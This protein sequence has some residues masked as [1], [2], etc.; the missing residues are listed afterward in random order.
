M[1]VFN[2]CLGGK[3]RHLESCTFTLVPIL[4]G[5]GAETSK[6]PLQ[7]N[8]FLLGQL[9]L[10]NTVIIKEY[11]LGIT[12]KTWLQGGECKCGRRWMIHLQNLP[13]CPLSFCRL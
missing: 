4:A 9:L 10:W 12:G 1:E 7:A 3:L 6:V 2:A 11:Y 8:L 5:P 13:L